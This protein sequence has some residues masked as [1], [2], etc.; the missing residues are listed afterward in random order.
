MKTRLLITLF[1]VFASWNTLSAQDLRYSTAQFSV[2][3]PSFNDADKEKALAMYNPTT[4][5]LRL[6]TDILEVVDNKP[7]LD[8]AFSDE[9]DG[10]PLALTVKID[11][12]G[13]E[14]KSAKNNGEE[15]VFQTLIS[16]NGV[17]RTLPV[18]YKYIHAPVVAQQSSAVNFRL[19]FVIHLNHSDFGLILPKDCS[20]IVMKVQDAWLNRTNQ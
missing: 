3:C 17:E 19:G 18:T 5:V 15:Y 8:T 16:C 14:F 6:S 10:I 1:I 12:P 20:D 13:I 2:S 4:H 11:I 9:R 7:P